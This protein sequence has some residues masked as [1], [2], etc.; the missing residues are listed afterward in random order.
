MN[1]K[2]DV[3]NSTMGKYYALK[4]K[5]D[6]ADATI[7]HLNSRI[8]QMQTVIN[9]YQD[10]YANHDFKKKVKRLSEIDG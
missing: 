9:S 1:N 4:N 6:G 3:L 8:E 5:L 10:H 7:K 2:Q